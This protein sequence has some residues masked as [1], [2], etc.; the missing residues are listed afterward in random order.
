MAE[1]NAPK[2]A[3]EKADRILERVLR[4][5][6]VISGAAIFTI[7]LSTTYGVF[8]RY[9]LNMPEPYSYEV[10]V[11]LFLICI[12][13]AIPIVQRHRRNIR[14]DFL[15]NRFSSKAQFFLTNIFVPVT[16]L[17]YVVLITWQGWENVV[18]SLQIHEVSQSI[19]RELLWPI[20]MVIPI[21]LGLLGLVLVVQLIRGIIAFKTGQTKENPI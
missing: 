17:F 8:R 9:A 3:W 20:K 15:A 2:N 5:C 1:N 16:A 11:I 21:G 19:W 12:I 13:M 14:V 7:M 10:S 6:L 4:V 18:Y